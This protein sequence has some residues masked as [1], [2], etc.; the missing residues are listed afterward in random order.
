MRSFHYEFVMKMNTTLK[1]IANSQGKGIIGVLD[2]LRAYAPLR[3]SAKS[4]AQWLADYFSSLLVLSAQYKFKPVIGNEYYLYLKNKEWK[5]SL[6][7]PQSWLSHDPGMYFAR[8]T[9]HTDMSWSVEPRNDWQDQPS[10]NDAVK[11]LQRDFL[12]SLKHENSVTE[13]LP[14]YLSQLPYYQRLGANALARSLK[15]SLELYVGM[16]ESSNL[17]GLYMLAMITVSNQE[18]LKFKPE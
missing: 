14:F 8:C 5:L 7:E 10:L 16:H 18:L 15:L 1:K 13:K 2:D 3:V 12:Q 4:Y 11:Q 9:L 6:I 17:S